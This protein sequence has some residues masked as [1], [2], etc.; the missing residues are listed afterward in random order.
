MVTIL[1]IHPGHDSGCS[2]IK[3][4]KILAAADEERFRRKKFWGGGYPE[5]SVKF[6]LEYTK[7]KI[8]DVD[9]IAIPLKKFNLLELAKLG[10][11]Y[12][13][14]PTVLYNKFSKSV[15]KKIGYDYYSEIVK[16]GLKNQFGKYPKIIGIDHHMAHASSAYY[17]SGMKDA[18]VI[19]L[20]GV[21]GA[22]SATVNITKNGR[23]KR[24][25]STLEPGSL[26]HFYESL[27][28]GIGF[29]INS[30]EYKV[31]GMAAYGDWR[32]GGYE[33]LKKIAPRV[34]GLKF[35]RKKQWALSSEYKDNFWK[36]HVGESKL[37]KRLVEKHGPLNVAAAGQKI[38]EELM[39]DWVKNIVKKFRN[40]N[41][42]AAGGV[43]LNIKAN[44]RVVDELGINL[45][46]FPHAGDGG[47][48]AGSALNANYLLNPK[49]EFEKIESLALG[50]E[51][52]NKEILIEL[53]KQKGIKYKKVENI[54][55]M[56]AKYISSG[57]IV[58]WF[59]GRMEFGPR[60][61]GNRS[62]LA[63]P[64]KK[65]YSD[66]VNLKVKFREEWRPFC[67]SMLEEES[68]KYLVNKHDA[69]F[70][71]VG[72]DVFKEKAKEVEGV[73]HVDGTTR[74]QLVKKEVY[75]KYWK[76]I[77]DIKKKIGVPVVLNTSFNVKG[78][79][80]VCTP[81]DALR[82]FLNCGMEYLAIGD[83]FVEKTQK[84]GIKGAK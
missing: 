72:F 25:S 67:P 28:E 8:E 33:E 32:K 34:K 77:H 39:I 53:K 63:N 20:D 73:V 51:F 74:P 60:A 54:A 23:I 7:T 22:I 61:L 26:G 50:P 59:Q 12:L 15:N 13:K 42:C 83:Y 55:E 5:N 21:G 18:I 78:E 16:K 14:H 4:G 45:F 31:M 80:I 41:I 10:I 35:I 62:I 37:V 57:K 47:L 3:D 27:T 40:K 29:L 68:S 6:V 48:S 75:E 1:G 19:T 30:D 43:F 2:L 79:P 38:L 56:S 65:K 52:T 17:S 81:K 11:R 66:K 82:T 70:M 69:P 76:L 71:V 24:V 64:T 36:V 49:T 9:A 44:K 58:G 84:S 46:V